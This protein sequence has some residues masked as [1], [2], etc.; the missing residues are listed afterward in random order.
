MALNFNTSFT[1]GSGPVGTLS[2]AGLYKDVR[3]Q[4]T[5]AM[6]VRGENNLAYVSDAGDAD[7]VEKRITGLLDSENP[8]INNARNRGLQGAAKRGM[9]NSSI[10]QGAAER[11]AIESALPIASADAN[12]MSQTRMLNQ[13]EL[14]KGLMQDR[15]IQNDV[16]TAK[17]NA[18]AAAAGTLA[19]ARQM[20]N[21]GEAQRALQLQL[22]RERFGFE[23]EQQGLGRQFEDYMARQGYGFDLGRLEAGFGFDIGRANN[24]AQLEDNLASNAAFRQ[25][26]LQDNQF[27]RDFYGNLALNFQ[28]ADIRNSSDFYSQLAGAVFQNPE[29]FGNPEYLSGIRNFFSSNIFDNRFDSFMDQ[30]FGGR[31]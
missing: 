24:A 27:N 6:G 4:G 21:D 31:G 7:L 25:D 17:Y 10:S 23:G 2:S 14:N 8:Y 1:S 13:T 16:L 18:D 15:Q 26:W 30:M 19:A 20:F 12:T 5:P 22:Q 28:E 3:A 9:L 11:S 29:V